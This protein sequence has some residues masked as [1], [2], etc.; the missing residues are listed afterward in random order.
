[1]VYRVIIGLAYGLAILQLLSKSKSCG[2]ISS[3]LHLRALD[4]MPLFIKLY[5]L[6]TRNG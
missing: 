4:W 3:G 1:M 6:C 5:I 2:D